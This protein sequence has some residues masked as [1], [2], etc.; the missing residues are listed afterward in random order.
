MV[1]GNIAALRFG[2]VF[3][4]VLLALSVS[5]LKSYKRGQPS[6]VMLKGQTR[7]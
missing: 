1:T 5:S 4:G 3:G 7:P 2:I 6:P